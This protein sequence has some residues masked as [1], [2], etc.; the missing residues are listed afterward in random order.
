[1]ENRII[2]LFII[3]AALAGFGV[4]YYSKQ[5]TPTPEVPAEEIQEGT[6][7]M[8]KTESGISFEILKEAPND[9]LKPQPGQ[10][11]TVHYS[12]WLNDD[13]NPGKKFDSS[14]DRGQPFQFIVGVGQVIKGWDESVLDMKVGEKRRVIIPHQL[15]YGERGAPGA[16]PPYS[17]LIFDIEVLD[18][19]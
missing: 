1:M 7:T 17:D 12:G 13:G 16:I 18:A 2:F 4:F 14:V 9:A 6:P 19:R 11:A 10:V 15:A 3:L 5:S 8:Q